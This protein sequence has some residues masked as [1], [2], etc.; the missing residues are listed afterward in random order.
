LP[1]SFR[2][3][4][5][6]TI[7]MRI[8]RQLHIVHP[9][10]SVTDGMMMMVE[11]VVTSSS[12]DVVS[13]VNN[14]AEDYMHKGVCSLC[15]VVEMCPC[16]TPMKIWKDCMLELCSCC[17]PNGNKTVKSTLLCCQYHFSRQ[18]SLSVSPSRFVAPL[19]SIDLFYG[20]LISQSYR[21]LSSMA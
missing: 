10:T 15:N 17:S 14:L 3:M 19:S 13:F 9:S 4:P 8:D 11:V 5:Q 20:K 18:Y 1:S 16:T 12:R 6:T 7:G 2:V 21:L